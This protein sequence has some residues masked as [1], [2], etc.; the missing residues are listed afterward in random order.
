MKLWDL[1]TRIY[2]WLQAALFVAMA[3]TGL[4][5]EGP[6]A[7]LGLALLTLL[8]WRI[9]WG[10]WGSD[11]SRFSQ[12]ICSPATVIKYIK[13]KYPETAGHNPAGGYMVITLI[14]CLLLQCITGLALAGMLDPLPD[15]ELWLN[16][17]IFEVCVVIHENLIDVLFGLVTLHLCAI[18]IYKLRSKPLVMAMITGIQTQSLKGQSLKG[19]APLRFC[20]NRKALATFLIVLSVTVGLYMLSIE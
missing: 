4:S 5:G 14:L 12:F 20:S 7:Y 11:T 1:P 18:V 2:H 15:S 13:G 10:I 8:L 6:H 17:E 9:L 19:Q 16:D 3:V